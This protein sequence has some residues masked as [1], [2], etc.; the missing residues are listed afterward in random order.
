MLS[1]VTKTACSAIAWAI[2]VLDMFSSF[3][4]RF[5]AFKSA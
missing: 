3:R 2:F 1:P 4:Y 5:K